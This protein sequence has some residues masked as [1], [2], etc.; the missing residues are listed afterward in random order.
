M[1]D[2]QSITPWFLLVAAACAAV[3]GL[4]GILAGLYVWW[5]RTNKKAIEWFHEFTGAGPALRATEANTAALTEISANLE[6]FGTELQAN[7]AAIKDVEEK[8]DQRHNDNTTELGAL[9]NNLERTANSFDRFTEESTAA[10][11]LRNEAI[12]AVTTLARTTAEMLQKHASS[13]SR[14]VPARK[15]PKTPP[16]P[17]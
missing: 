17:A 9:S 15:R 4:F 1:L 8:N 11:D 16:Q 10:A 13:S 3:T 12:I 5:P 2:P 14:H 6:A 7:R